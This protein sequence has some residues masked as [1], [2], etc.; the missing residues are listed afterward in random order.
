M[1]SKILKQFAIAAV[2]AASLAIG[3]SA[4][5]LF[6]PVARVNDSVVTEFE[7][8]QR[9]RFLQVLNAPGGSRTSVL[10]TLIDDRLRLQEVRQ[11]GLELSQ[12]ELEEGLS[13]FAGRANLSV[14]EFTQALAAQGVDTETF[15]DFVATGLAWRNLIRARFAA[16][17]QISEA[18]IDRALAA[19]AGGSGIRV[20]L[21]EIIIPAPPERRAEVQALAERIAQAESIGEFASFARQHSATRTRGAGGRLP[22]TPINQLP[23]TLRPIVL[24]L[25][26]GEITDPLPITNAVALFQL[27][28]IEETGDPTPEFAAIEYAAYYIDGGR[29]EAALNRAESIR[30]RVDVCDDLYGIAQGQPEEVLDRGSLPP[31][32]IPDDIAIELAK[33]DPGEVSTTLTRANGQT[34]VFLMLCGRSPALEEEIDRQ[35]V[36]NRLR[37]QR[38]QGL[39]DSLLAERRANARIWRAE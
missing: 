21:S 17:V 6:E 31:S 22:W 14:E 16:R 5:G 8:Q 9:L 19:S 20:L 13:E 32:E 10:D 26:V 34:L 35:A 2:A 25:S 29:T 38:L 18:E 39:A 33:L 30:H 12:E 23:A 24:G 15:R 36:A 11:L 28:A 4:Q 1:S 37:N 3:A 7:I 27:R